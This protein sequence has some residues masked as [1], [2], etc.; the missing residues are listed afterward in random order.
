[1][2]IKEFKDSLLD[3][4]TG[5]VYDLK[6]GA[7]ATL[8]QAQE[9]FNINNS[10]TPQNLVPVN[11]I[12]LNPQ[13]PDA[14]NYQGIISGGLAT[15]NA[16]LARA[17]KPLIAEVPK[18]DVQSL[19]DQLGGNPPPSGASLY[20]STYGVGPTQEEM[21][22]KQETERKAQ[23]D[24]DLFNAQMRAINAEATAIPIKVEKD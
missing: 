8:A 21:S 9:T 24:L 7:L 22:T 2:A 20:E 18:S 14:N 10:I 19:L 23:E 17:N 12:N 3:T 1:M 4:E 16:A 13:Q 11:P 6:T 5:S 15:G